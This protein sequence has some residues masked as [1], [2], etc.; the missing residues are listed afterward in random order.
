LFTSLSVDELFRVAEVGQEVRCQAGREVSRAGQTAGDV[1]FLL[2][3]TLE[4]DQGGAAAREIAAPAVIN[5]EEVLQ[6]TPLTNT[7]RAMEHSIGFRVPAS[8]F[9]TMV[10]DNVLMAQSLFRLLL[11]DRPHRA[12]HAPGPMLAGR[13]LPGSARLFRQDPLLAGA[14]AAQLLAL[15]A[16]A[17]EVTLTAGKALFDLD[18]APA[19]YQIEEGEVRLEAPDRDPMLASSGATFG[20]ADTLAGITPGWRATGTV[21]GRALRLER[22]D[23]FAVLADHVDLMQSLFSA[24]IALRA[25]GASSAAGQP[26]HPYFA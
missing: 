14:S 10:S 20:V 9:L 6:G 7:I 24:A 21:D 15:R 17:S 18:A 12:T 4:S 16:A 26:E 25:V 3:G 2:E 13:Q 19:I 8:E 1:F 22:D 5:V 23:L 11:G